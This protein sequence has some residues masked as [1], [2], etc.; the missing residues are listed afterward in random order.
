MVISA[1]VFSWSYASGDHVLS[2]SYK[3][4]ADPG[5]ANVPLYL[6]VTSSTPTAGVDVYL[7]LDRDILRFS[8][9]EFLT[10]FQ[11]ARYDTTVS[12]KLK[13]ALRRHHPDS[14]SL[15]PLTAG[16]DTLG[17]I[18]VKVTSADLLNDVESEISYWENPLTPY[19]DNRLVNP[20]SSFVVPPALTLQPGSVFIRHPLYGD[21]ND[22]GYPYTIAD[23]IF[24]VNFLTGSQNLTPRQRAN[25]DINRD[26]VQGSMTDF[27]ELIR[28]VTEQ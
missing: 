19:E 5:Q 18:R 20:D 6:V 14:T 23:V 10:R 12:G 16:T 24:M 22:D 26:G 3:V 21:L 2:L 27:L 8:G 7:Q 11:Y 28:I 9:V 25:A 17:V 4:T 15:G 13:I 1:G